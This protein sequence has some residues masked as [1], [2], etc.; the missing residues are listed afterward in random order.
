MYRLTLQNASLYLL[1]SKPHISI[2]ME[3]IE[4]RVII[5]YLL[6]NHMTITVTQQLHLH[7]IFIIMG[8]SWIHHCDVETKMSSK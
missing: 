6:L 5:K 2:K 1:L 8:E 4:Q 7:L 3:R